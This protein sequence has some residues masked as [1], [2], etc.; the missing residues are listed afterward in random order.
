MRLALWA[1]PVR[2]MLSTE[3]ALSVHGIYNNFD[4]KIAMHINECTASAV[5]AYEGAALHTFKSAHKRGI[6]TIYEI[7]SSDW[8][9]NKRLAEVLSYKN[10]SDE[11]SAICD[12]DMHLKRKDEELDLA[13]YVVVPSAHVFGTM[14]R[15]LTDKRVYVVSYGAPLGRIYSKTFSESGSALKI[16]YVGSIQER[17]GIQ[18]LFEA[19]RNCNCKIELTIVGRLETLSKSISN[20]CKSFIRH[21]SLPH[22]RVI[23]LMRS[24]DMLINPSLSEGCSLVA[25][26][27]LSVGLPVIV[28]KNCGVGEIVIDGRE[29]F[30][31]KAGSSEEISSRIR[32][33]YENRMLLYA[34]SSYAFKKSQSSSW[35]RYQYQWKNMIAN[36]LCDNEND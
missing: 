36:I 6:K 9:W 22:D 26:E 17:K 33:I 16:L 10:K 25:L 28:T 3:S 1:T 11:L 12:A 24:S 19:I 23:E 2:R 31:V 5:Y 8:Y 27:A 35:L 4:R 15:K 34:M 13:D 21:D 14:C 18:I 20:D 7:S 32:Y 30:I 29:G